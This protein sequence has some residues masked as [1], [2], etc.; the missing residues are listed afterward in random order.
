MR[1]LLLALTFLASCTSTTSESNT[2]APKPDDVAAEPT[3]ATEPASPAEPSSS[4]S[5]TRPATGQLLGVMQTHEGLT[6]Q[7]HSGGCRKAEDVT[8]A[9]NA[10]ELVITNVT[11]DS[12]EAVFRLGESVLFP[13]SKLPSFSKLGMVPDAAPVLKPGTTPG[14]TK[15]P[16]GGKDEPIYGVIVK[17]DGL[18]VRVSSGGCTAAEH[19]TAWIEP[20]KTELVHLVRLQEDSCEAWVPAGELLHFTWQQLGVTKNEARL[21]NPLVP[22]DRS[23]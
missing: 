14:A 9:V 23:E 13:W 19:F 10:G 3:P 5:S 15:A 6:L 4:S 2:T 22:I 18:D 1:P 8:F 12:C 20:G 7:L 11:I 21:V 17:D 16:A